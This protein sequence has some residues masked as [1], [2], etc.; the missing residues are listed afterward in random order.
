MAAVGTLLLGVAWPRD[1]IGRSSARLSLRG[2]AL[3][4]SFV[5]S[6]L[7]V[8]TLLGMPLPGAAWILALGPLPVSLVAFARLYGYSVRT[9]ATGFAFSV[10]VAVAL[11]PLAVALGG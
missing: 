7:A 1:W 2:L 8:V 9:A 4:L 11:L 5:P 6:V 3:H 10:A